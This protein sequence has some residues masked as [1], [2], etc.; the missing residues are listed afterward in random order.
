MERDSPP[1]QGCAGSLILVDGMSVPVS[2]VVG[3]LMALEPTAPWSNTYE[4]TAEAI[5]RAA[6]SDPLFADEEGGEAR[7]AS[8]LVSLAWHE[9]R[10][11]PDA[12]SKD[13]RFLCL[14][15]VARSYLP[16]PKKALQDP[17]TCTRAAMR[18]L[19]RSFQ[20][21]TKRPL[22]ERLAIYISGYCERGHPQS[23]MRMRL[24]DKLL[25]EHPLPPPSREATTTRAR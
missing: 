23:R 18:I 16:E 21:C 1:S 8:L 22:S 13:G 14:Y 12:K 17:E 4:K 7:T 3:L 24:A 11:R 10:L 2:W 6:E 15:Q 5:A 25:E 20:T 19:K 9:S